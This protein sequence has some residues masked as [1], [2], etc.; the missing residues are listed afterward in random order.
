MHVPRL[1]RAL[2]TFVLW[3]VV[4]AFFALALLAS[5]AAQGYSSTT[6][7][8][9]GF[10][11]AVVAFLGAAL[12]ALWAVGL[13]LLITLGI[14]SFF[15][16]YDFKVDAEKQPTATQPSEQGGPSQNVPLP[17]GWPFPKQNEKAFLDKTWMEVIRG[18]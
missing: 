5:C 7:F 8:I 4:I 10:A 6:T 2:P 9:T 16:K 11:S 17:P 12:G 3:T 1:P 15:P 13:G 14:M 18:R